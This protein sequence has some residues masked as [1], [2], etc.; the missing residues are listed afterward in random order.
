MDWGERYDDPVNA[1]IVWRNLDIQA[2]SNADVKAIRA[3]AEKNSHEKRVTISIP[4]YKATLAV[5]DGVRADFNQ[6]F[7]KLVVQELEAHGM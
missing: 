2:N 5:Y 1:A 6:Q 3:L 4:L 7:E